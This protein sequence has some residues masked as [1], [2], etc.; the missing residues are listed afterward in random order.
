MTTHISEIQIIPVKPK[1]RLVGFASLVLDKKLYL[2]SIAIHSKLD[3]S[4]YR[5]TYPTKKI[6]EKGITLFHPL[7]KTLSLEIEEAV[8]TK[9]KNVTKI[10]ND[11]YHSPYAA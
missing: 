7:N 5:L 1:N 10:S 11:R 3:G 2:S 8:I 4:G 9:F 6:G